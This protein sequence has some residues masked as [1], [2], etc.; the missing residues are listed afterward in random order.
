MKTNTVINIPP[1]S[2]IWQ[3]FVS[4]VMGGNEL[5]DSLK[6]NFSRKK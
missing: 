3:N 5:Q 1:Q 4:Q 6:Y 2:H